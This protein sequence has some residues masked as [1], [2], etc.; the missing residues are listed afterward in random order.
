MT[1]DQ[2]LITMTAKRFGS[3]AVI[4]G[5]GKLLGVV[6]DGDLRRNM[7][8]ALLSRQVS[9]IMNPAPK[10][11]GPDAL[12][13]EALREMNTAARPFTA[14]FVVDDG[15]MAIGILHIHDLLRAGLA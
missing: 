8:P 7:G 9:E 2:A 14:L 13:E 4:D 11:I 3:L 10:T 15:G 6:T 5:A 1:M 12:A